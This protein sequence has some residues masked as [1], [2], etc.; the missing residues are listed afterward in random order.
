MKANHDYFLCTLASK[1]H[2]THPSCWLAISSTRC[3]ASLTSLP[4]PCSAALVS[5]THFCPSKHLGTLLKSQITQLNVIWNTRQPAGDWQLG[6][7][8]GCRGVNSITW[9]LSRYS[10]LLLP[11]HYLFKHLRAPLCASAPAGRAGTP[12]CFYVVSRWHH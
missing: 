12:A 10:R 8:G 2:H 4:P 7:L 5:S 6:F 11:I 9:Q 1:V 3:H